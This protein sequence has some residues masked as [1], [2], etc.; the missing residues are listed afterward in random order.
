MVCFLSAKRIEINRD[1][2]ACQDQ[3]LGIE[4][5]MGDANTIFLTATAKQAA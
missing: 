1:Y 4:P 3:Q 5:G 2:A